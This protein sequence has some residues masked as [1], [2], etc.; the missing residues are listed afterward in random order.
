MPRILASKHIMVR[1]SASIGRRESPTS[2]GFVQAL[3]DKISGWE[4]HRSSEVM[5]SGSPIVL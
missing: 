3:C 2:T 5:C 1:T 4:E